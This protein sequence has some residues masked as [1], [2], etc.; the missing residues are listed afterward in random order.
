MKSAKNLLIP[1]IVMILLA[2]GVV[3]F[4]ALDNIKKKP[5][6]TTGGQTVD[7]LYISPVEIASV[8]V[9][10]KTGNIDVRVEKKTD[11]GGS[12]VYTYLGS[13]KGT[14]G[15]SQTAMEEF[16]SALTSFVGCTT[17][18]ESGNLSDFGLDDP[19]FTVT[20]TK[21]DGT[22]A[23][24]R[25]G[26][27][28]PDKSH[29]Y[30]CSGDSTTVYY[31]SAEKYSYALKVSNDFLDS[32]LI[33]VEMSD[34]DSVRFVRK[35]D[36]MDLSASC[37]YDEESDSFSFRFNKPFEI[38]SST[39]FDKL[40]ENI[41][42]LEAK[43]YE[44]SSSDRLTEY[45]LSNPEYSV[46][47][48]LKSGSAYT[49][50]LSS[51]H[52]GYYYGRLNGTGKIFKI[53]S[54]RIESIESPVLVLIS[55]FVF[56]DTCDNVVSVECSGPEKKFVLKLDVAKGK[57]ISDSESSVTLDGRNAKVSNA[58]GRSFAAMLYESVFCIN[59][60][61]VEENAVIPEGSAANTTITVFDRNHSA[62]IY[63][64]YKRNDTSFYVCKNGQYTKFYVYG[65]ELYNDGGTDTY[66]YGLWPAY[67]ILTK[68]ITN[69]IN[70][71][72]EIPENETASGS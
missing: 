49:M 21:T 43:E 39:Y 2:I 7:L 8:N 35:K 33:D 51:R 23:V 20:V 50:D 60:G 57:A 32:R 18:S 31:I 72:Y 37:V 59:I 61:G 63:E 67:E 66:D 15:Y 1:L 58:S 55:D 53:E 26:N 45:G 46:T 47:V 30:I 16:V 25:I 13:D 68:A 27:L 69:N 52:N 19:A 41:C 28:S 6:G 9:F 29:C 5:G 38:D 48:R 36:S 3:V 22:K 12:P 10:H 54:D 17:L 14:D 24:I 56:Y 42:S 64:F 4:F 40:I 70:G 34:I 65:R 71:M 44:D 11:N 62:V